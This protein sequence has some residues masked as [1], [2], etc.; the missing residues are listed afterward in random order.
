[1]ENGAGRGLWKCGKTFQQATTTALTPF[2]HLESGPRA[3]GPLTF[4]VPSADK[5]VPHPGREWTVCHAQS[6][7]CDQGPFRRIQAPSWTD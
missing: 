4:P 5:A 3:V 7:S 6:L 2:P 1:M